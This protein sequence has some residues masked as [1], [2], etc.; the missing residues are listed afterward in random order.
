[1]APGQGVL[2][3]DNVQPPQ[4]VVQ[5]GPE[6]LLQQCSAHLAKPTA[7]GDML[8]VYGDCTPHFDSAHGWDPASGPQHYDHIPISL[9]CHV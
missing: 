4:K 7:F 6:Y 3:S 1:M 5:T 2:L 8:H 9:V